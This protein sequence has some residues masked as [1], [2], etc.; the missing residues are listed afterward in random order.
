MPTLQGADACTAA[1]AAGRRRLR[2]DVPRHRA[3][4]ARQDPALRVRLLRRRRAPA[5]RPGPLA[6]GTPTTTP[7]PPRPARRRSWPPG[8]VPIAHANDG[9]GSI[10]IP[11]AVNGLVGLKPTRDRLA[12]DRMMREMPVRIVSD[13][14]L[15]RSVRDTAAF[16]REAEKVW[17][18]PLPRADR[19]PH[20]PEPGP[21]A[22]RRRHRGHRPRLR[23]EVAELTLKD[24]GAARVARPPGRGGR[25]P[26]AGE[27]PRRLPPLLV[28]ARAGHRRDGA[29]RTSARPGTR[30]S[31]TTSRLGLAGHAPATCTGCR[32]R[33]PCCARSQRLARPPPRVS[34]TSPSRRPWPPRRR[35]SGTC[36]PTRTTT[37]SWSRLLD[38]VAFTPLQNATGDPAISPAPR[39]HRRRAAAGH[40]V[41]R[42]SGSRGDACSSSPTS[43]RRPSA[44]PGSRTSEG[45]RPSR[46]P[47]AADFSPSGAVY[48][49]P[50][51]PL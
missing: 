6:R 38:W 4:P 21:A 47:S 7:A 10:R 2:P 48:R 22:D 25:H 40:D 12:Q 18:N 50:S 9:G 32:W 36:D 45:P 13:G 16:F 29:R 23:P 5:A 17:R 30:P 24:R 31:S 41:R 1:P 46:R 51:L 39:D 37:R 26:V 3:D 14:V 8:V 33:S 49:S 20:P 35:G 43:S 42:R 28:D 15:T 11:A 27:L 19:R 34:T 44:G